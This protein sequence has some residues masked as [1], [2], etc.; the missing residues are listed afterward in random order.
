MKKLLILFFVYSIIAGCKPS[1]KMTSAKSIN[2]E[3]QLIRSL[4]DKYITAIK[5]N[6][7]DALSA[8]FHPTA[9]MYG[10]YKH[11]DNNMPIADYIDLQI[12]KGPSPN[13]I[14]QIH[15]LEITGRIAQLKVISTDWNG[16][17]Y[18]DYYT[19]IKTVKAAVDRYG[20]IISDSENEV[21]LI[22]SKTFYLKGKTKK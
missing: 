3:A 17:D 10:Y 21:W 4:F 5:T 16:D 12:R 14:S 15:N 22:A 13:V 8:A 18:T 7:K 2:T 11:Y 19:C 20:N 9:R 1:E 6:D